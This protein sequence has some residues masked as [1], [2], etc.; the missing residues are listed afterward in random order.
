VTTP[1]GRISLEAAIEQA[2][3]DNVLLLTLIGPGKKGNSFRVT[4]TSYRYVWADGSIKLQTLPGKII[5]TSLTDTTQ[6]WVTTED[7]EP[8]EMS[9]PTEAANGDDVDSE[10]SGDAAE[11]GGPESTND[12]GTGD[13]GGSTATHDADPASDT[14]SNQEPQTAPSASNPPF[15][16]GYVIAD[17]RLGGTWPRT[18]PDDGAWYARSSRPTNGASYWWANG[19]GVG[20]SCG[21]DAAPY[22]VTLADGR[23]QAWTTWLR[24][25]DTWGGRV[26]GLWIPSAA[27][28]G[29]AVDGL[30]PGLPHC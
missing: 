30:P 6:V 29:V 22:T 19:L 20:F 1:I 17:P 4:D 27:A 16:G 2:P 9:S 23:T 15:T 28:A 24:S 5:V 25:T 26:A 12:D 7:E 10:G 18:D 13:E 21:V 11:E 8:E 14:N 3:Q